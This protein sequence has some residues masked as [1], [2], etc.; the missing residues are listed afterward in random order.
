MPRRVTVAAR[1][2]SPETAVFSLPLANGQTNRWPIIMNQEY[3]VVR[4]DPKPEPASDLKSSDTIEQWYNRRFIYNERNQTI[5]LCFLYP[6]EVDLD[7]IRTP[8]D[9]MGW[10]YHLCGKPWM[11]KGAIREFL[12]RVSKI[13]ARA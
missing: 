2:G 4:D 5:T 10:L 8:E 12:K 7:R 9:L 3:I 11:D 1:F 6:Y 13:K